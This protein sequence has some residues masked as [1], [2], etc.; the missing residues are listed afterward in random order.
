MA[1]SPSSM[2]GGGPADMAEGLLLI[3]ALWICVMRVYVCWDDACFYC[4]NRGE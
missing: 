4:G 1:S 2:R 3:I